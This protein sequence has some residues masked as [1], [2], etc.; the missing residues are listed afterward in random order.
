MKLSTLL[1]LT[2][3][4]LAAP[5][6]ANLRAEVFEGR[7]QLDDLRARSWT[8]G[9]GVLIAWTGIR[10][11]RAAGSDAVEIVF[12]FAATA[13]LPGRAKPAADA[14]LA[15]A[16]LTQA[17]VA[18][19]MLVEWPDD[20]GR[21][22][23]VRAQNLYTLEDSKNNL[24]RSVVFWEQEVRSKF[25]EDAPDLDTLELIHHEQ[26]TEGTDPAPIVTDIEVEQA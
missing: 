6:I 8:S 26:N 22:T 1:S 2:A 25:D 20:A 12:Q 10:S 3:T 19:L 4:E 24:A 5:N 11:I 9:A 7:A 23:Q 21:P 14:K 15:I 13:S 18:R 17:I 16:D